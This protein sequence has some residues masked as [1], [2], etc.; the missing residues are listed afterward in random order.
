MELDEYY[1]EG[2][3]KRSV[4]K[5]RIQ[6][7]NYLINL[8]IEDIK[9]LNPKKIID[10][11]CG[12]G[13]MAHMIKN[14]TQASIYGTDISKKGLLLAK[15][16]GII[17]KQGDLNKKIHYNKDIF[18]VVISNQV[19]EHVINPDFYLSECNRILRR[20]G[21]IVITTPNLAAWY[22]RILLLIGVYPIF[23]EA[24]M[25]NKLAGTKF[26]K[27]FAA[28][29]Q[30]V[31]HIKVLTVGALSDLLEMNGFRIEN[32]KGIKRGFY[33]TNKWSLR[34][35]YVLIDS[36]FSMIP[37]LSSDMLIIATKVSK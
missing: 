13:Q 16:K 15:Q 7:L 11:G 29:K 17:T 12:E 8:F 9:E 25:R 14:R 34:S 30:G 4:T 37:N 18:D 23:L 22:N 5:E 28:S 1:Q 2:R 26:M 27:K 32:I 35:L 3:Y 33:Y 20:G 6:F 10:V 19:I 36:I 24:S 21:R 31:G